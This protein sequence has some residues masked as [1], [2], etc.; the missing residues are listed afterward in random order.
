MDYL[1]KVGCQ[2]GGRYYEDSELL[3]VQKVGDKYHLVVRLHGGNYKE[4]VADHFVNALGWGAERFTDALGIDTQLTPVKHQ[5]FITRRLPLM[6]KDGDSLDMIIDRRHYHGFSA[7]YGQQF[8]HT[9]QIIGCASPDSD[10]YEAR[11]SLKYNSKEFLEIIGE[12]F[13]EW[14][15]DLSD[16]SFLSVWAGWYTEPRYIVDA[17]KGLLVGLRGHGFMLAQY[18][19]KLYVDQY[20][21]RDVPSYMKDLALSGKGL[22]ETAFK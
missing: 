21:G 13:S 12:M 4:Y 1:R 14:I 3:Q 8:A 15:P 19:A 5:A 9:G 10:G 2:H 18:L 20:L 7:V 6:G 11:Q 22:S 16:V 17:T